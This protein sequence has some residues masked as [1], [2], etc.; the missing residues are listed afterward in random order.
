[1]QAES[2]TPE[3]DEPVDQ[4]Y[5]IEGAIE[6]LVD[7]AHVASSYAMFYREAL[8]IIASALRCTFVQLEARSGGILVQE[9]H[10]QGSVQPAFW[11]GIT[12]GAII[13]G[14]AE[15]STRLQVFVGREV[16]ASVALVTAPIGNHGRQGG[17]LAAIYPFR[18]KDQVRG[19][20]EEVDVLC[21]LVSSLAGSVG[22]ETEERTLDE[23]GRV[24]KVA[25]FTSEVELAYAITNKLRTRD[26]AAQV[27]MAAVVGSKIRLLSV[28]GIDDIAPRSPGIVNLTGAM[29]ECADLGTIVV[30]QS[31]AYEDES[32]TLGGRMHRQWRRDV[33]DA[34]VAS[35]PLYAEEKLVAVLSIQR[36]G[37]APFD[38][39]QLAEFKEQVEP[40]AAG[41]EMVRF[42]RRP[43]AEHA[44]D[45]LRNFARSFVAAGARGRQIVLAVT[46]LVACWSVF[47]SLEHSV[48]APAT[49]AP[50]AGR[51]VAAGA[52]AVLTT[53]HV[54]PGDRV[55]QG[56][57][58]CEFDTSE[59][60]LEAARLRAEVASAEV[61]MYRALSEG[62]STQAELARTGGLAAKASLEF[63]QHRIENARV[64][65]PANGLILEGDHHNRIGDVFSKGET[66]FRLSE[67]DTWKVDVR[68]PE[69]DVDALAAGNS[70]FFATHSRPGEQHFVQIL[71]IA[72][73][74]ERFEGTNV[75]VAEAHCESADLWLRPG[76]EG[77][78]SI[79]AGERSPLW[80]ASH[81][82][83]D[84]L[85][86][87]LWL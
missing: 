67:G 32:A 48:T 25:A 12:E 5:T 38:P 80:L 65:A 20:L 85:R 36:T 15:P 35:L 31:Q 59:L 2:P 17:V 51:H 69:R 50:M 7:L 13:R 72:P 46:L 8:P 4:A 66:L 44:V 60:Q 56:D 73:A 39:E 41:L 47:G 9:E 23:V 83:V 27:A 77:F 6:A 33:G 57:L 45:N 82:L 86:M 37:K 11:K 1:M 76:M 34:C 71:R 55:E 74:A 75:F 19:L 79:N 14:L 49:L 24:R 16:D 58:L 64:V 43:L 10:S 62:N 30:D 53:V 42:A 3:L 29:K 78:V 22:H 63:V 68:V 54:K 28:S 40:Y 18:H 21:S 81:R 87:H 84:F 61:D 26:G 70:G 52:D